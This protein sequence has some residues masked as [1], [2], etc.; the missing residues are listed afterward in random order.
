MP[1][2]P[3]P[4]LARAATAVLLAAAV[5]G[6]LAGVPASAGSGAASGSAGSKSPDVKV[7]LW[8]PAGCSELADSLPSLVVL[9]GVEPGDVSPFVQVCVANAG[10]GPGILT[11]SVVDRLDLETGCSPGEVQV[12][13]TCGAGGPGELT[14]S[15]YQLVATQDRCD[16]SRGRPLRVGL[17]TLETAPLE[18]RRK[19]MPGGTACVTV[20]V[21]YLPPDGAARLATQTDRLTWRYAF[22]LTGS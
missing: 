13:P 14:S 10:S 11:L 21:G 20:A 6:A 3:R 15:V 7:G 16:G 4:R 18:L 2:V 12:D 5:T 9:E 1:R 17:G 19:L 8:G 22:D